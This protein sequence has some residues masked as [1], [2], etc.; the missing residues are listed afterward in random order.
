MGLLRGNT[1][2]KREVCVITD[3]NGAVVQTLDYYP[4]GVARIDAKVGGYAGEQRK[5]AGHEFDDQTGV[6]YLGTLE[7][8]G[9][10]NGG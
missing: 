4:Y 2:T 7:K 10:L 6:L 3:A 1:Y 9:S 8:L 5:F